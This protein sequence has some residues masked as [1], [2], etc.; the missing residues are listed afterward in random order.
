M[1]TPPHD[2]FQAAFWGAKRAVAEASEAA[3]RRHGVHAGQQ[4]ILVRLWE[5]D[6]L[7][8]GQ[9]ARRLGLSTPTVTKM[10]SRMEATGLVVRRPHPTDRRLV[11]IY[12]T[13]R[14]RELPE[15]ISNEMRDLTERA[16]AG[17]MPEERA[18]FIRSLTTVQRN[19]VSSPA[20][21]PV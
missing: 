10:T 7:T 18:Q 19:L 1:G 20:P 11:R 17:L 9:L 4:F 6:G 13:E 15:E 8:P 12:L 2:E 14:G 16:L 21:Q 3:Y 5:E